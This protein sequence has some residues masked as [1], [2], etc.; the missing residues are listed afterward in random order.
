[1]RPRKGSGEEVSI[2]A[3]NCRPFSVPT[4]P[5]GAGRSDNTVRD[6]LIP[7]EGPGEGLG[8]EQGRRHHL[9]RWR[10]PPRP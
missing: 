1:M 7:N 9:P 4:T 6:S 3:G 2:P 5:E 10:T 8:V